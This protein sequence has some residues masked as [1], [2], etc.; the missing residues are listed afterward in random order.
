VLRGAAVTAD[1]YA[2]GTVVCVQDPDMKQAWCLAA[3]ST[4]ATQDKQR[5]QSDSLMT[6]LILSDRPENVCEEWLVVQHAG[7]TLHQRTQ[8]S[9]RHR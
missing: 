7:E 5:T 8:P 3:R 6:P 1:R 4:D 9:F 2:V